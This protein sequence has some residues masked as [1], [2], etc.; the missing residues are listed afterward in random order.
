MGQSGG[1][2]WVGIPCAKPVL[3]KG[4]V[5]FGSFFTH[6]THPREATLAMPARRVH[7]RCASK[8]TCVANCAKM[9]TSLTKGIEKG[10]S[11]VAKKSLIYGL[12]VFAAVFFVGWSTG[13][14]GSTGPNLAFSLLMGLFAAACFWLV[15]KFGKRF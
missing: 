15:M 11:Q 14:G 9:L 5:R 3:G 1:A 10:D 7:T 12:V 8:A 13:M 6:A 4:H 2:I